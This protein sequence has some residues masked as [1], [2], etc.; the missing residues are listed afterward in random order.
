M[1]L[2]ALRCSASAFARCG[3]AGRLQPNQRSSKGV[4]TGTI[5]FVW[6]PA[7]SDC[8]AFYRC[9]L[10]YQGR[11]RGEDSHVFFVGTGILQSFQG[12]VRCKKEFS[13]LPFPIFGE[14]HT[15]HLC[16]IRYYT[17]SSGPEPF[18]TLPS[19]RCNVP[20]SSPHTLRLNTC[21]H[22]VYYFSAP[23]NVYHLQKR[24]I[25][26]PFRFLHLSVQAC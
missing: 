18:A 10:N 5:A 21:M 14:V 7:F 3:R 16:I 22:P 6:G 11:I 2:T 15:S 24:R 25:L 12:V 20:F 9:R 13:R 17:S 23:E 4:H 19:A 1:G 26:S 8:I